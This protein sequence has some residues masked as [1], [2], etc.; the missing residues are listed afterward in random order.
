MLLYSPRV[1]P[2]GFHLKRVNNITNLT[3]PKSKSYLGSLPLQIDQAMREDLL[4]LR[5]LSENI[6]PRER[7][8]IT[9]PTF[10]L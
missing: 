7:D 8:G 3:T 2:L 6:R 4:V 9:N 1:E 10:L 5:A